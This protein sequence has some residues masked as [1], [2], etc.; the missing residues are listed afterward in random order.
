[1][2]APPRGRLAVLHAALRVACG[3]AT[4]VPPQCRL[5]ALYALLGALWVGNARTIARAADRCLGAGS[6]SRLDDLECRLSLNATVVAAATSLF[7][8]RVIWRREAEAWEDWVAAHDV[9]LPPE[10]GPALEPRRAPPP[11][12]SESSRQRD[13]RDELLVATA[14]VPPRGRAAALCTLW[15]ASALYIANAVA[16]CARLGGSLLDDDRCRIS[17]EYAPAVVLG[18]LLERS[19]LRRRE[20]EEELGGGDGG[21]DAALPKRLSSSLELQHPPRD[22]EAGFLMFF[23]F[24][25]SLG[26]TL[27]GSVLLLAQPPEP[28][29]AALGSI[30][31]NVGCLGVSITLCILGIPYAVLRLRKA[32]SV[33]A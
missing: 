25:P 8:L 28:V 26:L 4:A 13:F 5:A 19:I 12:V 27:F 29:L 32:L 10:V 3:V 17:L 9:A 15:V 20:A 24:V 18:S 22:A 7:F 14:V 33:K 2:A 1:M 16:R 6:G 31:A 21:G 11:P 23:A 30:M